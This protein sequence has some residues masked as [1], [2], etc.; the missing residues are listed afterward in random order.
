MRRARLWS[1]W[2]IA[3]VSALLVSACASAPRDVSLPISGKPS[4]VVNEMVAI[5]ERIAESWR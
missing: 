1:K 5:L 2:A 3:W 4:E